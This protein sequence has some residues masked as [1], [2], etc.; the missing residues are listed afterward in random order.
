MNPGTDPR[1]PL[2]GSW[3]LERWVSVGDDGSEAEPL[4]ASPEGL[5]TY[6]PDGTMITVIGRP[7]AERPRFAS[8]DLTGGTT[9]ERAGACSTFIAYGGRWSTDGEVVVHDV[10]MSL[11]PNWVGSTQRRRF[12][13]S[14]AETRL[15]L[16]AP[17]IEVGGVTRVQRLTWARRGERS[18]MR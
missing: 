4:G 1:H 14:A 15:T 10:A 17:P 3:Q 12:E 5:L 8:G 16:A 6:A 7:I 13:L 18:G 9:D 11:F 2:V